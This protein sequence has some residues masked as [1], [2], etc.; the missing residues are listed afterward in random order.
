MDGD[1]LAGIGGFLPGL[2]ATL[3]APGLVAGTGLPDG[4][5]FASGGPCAKAFCRSL[6]F[7]QLGLLLSSAAS[8]PPMEAGF[9]MR[10][11]RAVEGASP[12][13]GGGFLPVTGDTGF[14]DTGGGME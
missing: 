9:G 10:Y 6:C 2:G 8:T 5:G 14:L 13:L 4:M 3:P 1:A 7:C 11:F 12:G